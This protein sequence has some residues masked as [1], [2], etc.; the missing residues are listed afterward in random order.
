MASLGFV[1]RW[2]D[3]SNGKLYIGSHKGSPDDGYLGG[4]T[5]FRRAYKKRPNDFVREILYE[6]PN[7]RELEQFIFDIEDAANNDYYYNLVNFAC[8]G[9]QKELPK[10][11]ITKKRIG[12][13]NRG[14][15]RTKAQIEVMRQLSTGNCYRGH[16]ILDTN[17][18]IEY[19]SLLNY[20]QRHNL[21]HTTVWHN[22]NG[23]RKI[24]KYNYLKYI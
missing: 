23:K 12:A 9:S 10:K 18:G 20:C 5:L 15:K 17:T 14:K 22:I 2:Y 1:Y 6:G 8:G 21:K 13:A 3:K 24:N 16:K 11:E 19:Q 4:G 7:Y